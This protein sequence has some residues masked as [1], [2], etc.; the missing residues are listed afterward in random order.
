MHADRREIVLAGQKESQIAVSD[1]RRHLD[2]VGGQTNQRRHLRFDRGFRTPRGDQL[3]DSGQMF[4]VFAGT[5]THPVKAKAT[6]DTKSNPDAG[7][8]RNLGNLNDTQLTIAPDGSFRFL[9]GGE[10]ESG[11]LRF[12]NPHGYSNTFMDPGFEILIASFME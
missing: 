5:M 9:I 11:V 6:E 8:F 10:P 1:Q 3:G 12:H 7:I 2:R 4:S